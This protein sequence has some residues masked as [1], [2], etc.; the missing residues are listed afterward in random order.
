MKIL[1]AFLLQT[2]NFFFPAFCALCGS[3]FDLLSEIKYGLCAQC[4]SAI[5]PITENT[6]NYCGKPLISEIDYCLS[7]RN[8]SGHSYKRQWA[9][10]PYTGKYR[11]LMKEYKFEKK[12]SIA[13]FFAEKV[14]N[15]LFDPVFDGAHVVPVPPRPGK[16]KSSGWDQVDYLVKRLEKISDIPVCRCLKR[17]ESKIQKQLNRDERLENLK[18]RIYLNGKPPKIAVVIDDV[19]T[20]G[21]TMEI[22]SSVLKENGTETVY[23]ICLFYG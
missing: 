13:D 7:C 6:C 5:I 4:L 18:G 9:L 17:R 10:F 22:C 11:R 12:L 2:K 8:G 14:K 3:S 20:T 16:I 1:N 19:T 21:A 23:G 15:I